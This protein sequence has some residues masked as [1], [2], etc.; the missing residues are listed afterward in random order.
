MP[1]LGLIFSSIGGTGT[2]LMRRV[3]ETT[4]AFDNQ[5]SPDLAGWVELALL[6][7]LLLAF[8]VFLDLPALERQ[9]VDICPFL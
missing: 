4:D 6:A 3:V 7:V 5:A 8:D 2:E 9:A 1:C